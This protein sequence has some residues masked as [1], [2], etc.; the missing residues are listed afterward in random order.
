MSA[1]EDGLP[2][3]DGDWN[4]VRAVV[5]G[6]DH[7]GAAAADN[8]L[9]LGAE[10]TLLA[11]DVPGAETEFGERA[12]LLE[13]LGARVDL[14]PGRTGELPDGTDLVVATYG[15]SGALRAATAAGVPVWGDLELAWRLRDRTAPPW[16]LVAGVEGPARTV[17]LL[18]SMLRTAGHR[19]VAVGAGGLPVVEAVMDPTEY[20]VLP[21]GVSAGQLSRARSVRAHSAAV[22]HGGSPEDDADLARAFEGVRVACVYHVA[23]RATEAMVEDADVVEGARAIGITLG[24]PGLSMLGVVEDVLADRAF[25]EDRRN[26]AAE[27]GTLADLADASDAFVLDVLAAAALARAFGVAPVAVRDALRAQRTA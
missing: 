8:L 5:V 12:T 23:D 22:I 3:R 9:H 19:T 17:G 18:A 7:D 15:G 4:G 26:H 27:L 25:V 2:G 14:G 6:L 24:T 10:V 21:V 11:E 13:M 1:A 16:L 20:D